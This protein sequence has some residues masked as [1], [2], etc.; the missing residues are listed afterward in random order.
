MGVVAV[1]RLSAV[2]RANTL[3][4][5]ILLMQHNLV[6]N[7]GE[8]TRASGE[9]ELY[10]FD[11]QECLMRLRWGRI[12]SLTQERL[13]PVVSISPR[14]TRPRLR[15]QA[16]EVVRHLMTF[17]KLKMPEI[18]E[19]SGGSQD[20]TRMCTI[21]YSGSCETLTLSRVH[22]DHRSYRHARPE[23]PFAPHSTRAA[24]AG[25]RPST[26]TFRRES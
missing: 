14:V 19:L 12:L 8:S 22:R 25:V 7:N 9:E 18:V 3:A 6:L 26:A 1:A 11:V 15:Y 20:P 24:R 2:S 16:V 17:G 13:G 4:A 23:P 10:E 5:V 21:M